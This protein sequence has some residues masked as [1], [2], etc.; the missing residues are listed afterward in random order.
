MSSST[1][2]PE[3]DPAIMPSSRIAVSAPIGRGAEPHVLTM[4]ARTTRWPL[5]TQSR[6]LFNTC[7]STLSKIQ[8]SKTGYV[9]CNFAEDHYRQGSLDCE[10]HHD[11]ASMAQ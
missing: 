11:N 3:T 9:P 6:A 4:V 1:Q 2:P 10:P 8:I 5:F 7:R